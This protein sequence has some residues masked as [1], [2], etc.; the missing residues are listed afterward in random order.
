MLEQQL[1]LRS[2]CLAVLGDNLKC[3]SAPHS[4]IL[5]FLHFDSLHSTWKQTAKM[6]EGRERYTHKERERKVQR[7]DGRGGGRERRGEGE[8]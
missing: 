4:W 7:K 2:P 5:A 8:W 6:E 1:R 3:V